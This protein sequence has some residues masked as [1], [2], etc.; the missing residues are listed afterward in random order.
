[1]QDTIVTFDQ[2]TKSYDGRTRVVEALD[3]QLRRG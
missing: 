1:M 2:V 3:L